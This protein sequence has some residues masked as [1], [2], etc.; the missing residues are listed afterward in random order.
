MQF[1][2]YLLAWVQINDIS[3]SVAFKPVSIYSQS[4]N[5]GSIMHVTETLIT[6]D[7][8]FPG[9]SQESTNNELYFMYERIEMPDRYEKGGI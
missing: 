2:P 5:T 3:F 1:A 9:L 7:Y 4:I 8:P 6:S